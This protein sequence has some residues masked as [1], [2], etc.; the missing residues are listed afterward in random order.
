MY[1]LKDVC[2]YIYTHT[3]RSIPT[4]V[5]KMQVQVSGPEIKTLAAQRWIPELRFGYPP[6]RESF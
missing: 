6:L 3:C 2:I 1:I 5:I 4:K